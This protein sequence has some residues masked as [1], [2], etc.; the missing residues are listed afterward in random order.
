MKKPLIGTVL[1]VLS[2]QGRSASLVLEAEVLEGARAVVPGQ[3]SNAIGYVV[4]HHKDQKDRTLL[5]AWL[6]QHAGTQVAFETG[7][8][9]VHAGV[10][11]RL[12]HCFGRGLLLYGDAIALK[13]KDVIRL[14]L[15]A[16]D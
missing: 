8:G 15:D 1:L 11:Q 16:P 10:L 2:I 14:R 3:T 4:L 5:S 13:E 6:H 9:T 7:D 12:K